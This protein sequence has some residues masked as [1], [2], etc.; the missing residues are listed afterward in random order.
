MVTMDK[1]LKQ[2]VEKGASDLHI[3]VGA[4]PQLRID[5][6][7]T[8]E[9]EEVLTA[10]KS[11]ELTYSLLNQEAIGRFEEDLELDMSFGIEGLSRFRLNVYQQR[12]AVCCAV[13]RIPY[14]IM[15][16]KDCGLPLEI[17]TEL[18]RKP[19]GLILVTG[20]TGSGKSTSL[21]AM[22]NAINQERHCHIITVED[23]IE[24]NFKHIKSI[25]E[26]REIGSD[27]HSF[28]D[29]LKHVLREDPDVILIGE[30]RDLETIQSAMNM[31]ETGH[32]V[33]ATLHTSDSVQTINRI[34]DV[35]PAAQQ[36]QVRTQLSFVLLAILAQQLIPKPESGRVLVTEILIANHAIRSLIREGKTHQIYSALQ[37]AQKEKMCT[38]NRSLYALCMKGVI[39]Q[40]EAMLRTTEPQDLERLLKRPL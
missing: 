7:L 16:V 11:K 3:T 24:Y 30:M 10:Q 27:T 21:A 22:I 29:A 25:V 2:M 33:F 31:A 39:S 26:Q 34:I 14:D 23:P 37:T 28:A 13:R 1:L 36:Q 15:S 6:K 35:F 5:E 18:C 12:G 38:M 4:T 17:V 8:N 32:L 20:S 19:K 9:G 40:E